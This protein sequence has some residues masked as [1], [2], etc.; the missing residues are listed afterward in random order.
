M[1]NAP[2]FHS[3]RS[4]D[5]DGWNI[6]LWFLRMINPAAHMKW[7]EFKFGYVPIYRWETC[8]MSKLDKAKV[9]VTHGK[10][11]ITLLSAS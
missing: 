3:N 4:D 6:W 5:F 8:D 10:S 1:A 7:I 11:Y 9:G 2:R